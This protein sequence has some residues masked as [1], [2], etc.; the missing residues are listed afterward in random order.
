MTY[1][2]L[3][4][5]ATICGLLFGVGLSISGMISPYKVFSFL[6]L[7]AAWDPSLAFVMGGALLV[8]F[9][10]WVPLTRKLGHPK[11]DAAFHGPSKTK[12]DWRVVLGP[13]PFGIGWALAGVCPAPGI[14]SIPL[15]NFGMWIWMAACIAG[16]WVFG[17]TEPFLPKA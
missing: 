8:C 10:L 15:F 7:N 14:A 17:K 11:C 12:L 9:P 1:P 4:A 13:I 5:T 3:N 2:S 6:K 16:L